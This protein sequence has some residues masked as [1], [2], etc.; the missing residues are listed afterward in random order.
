MY[1]VWHICREIGDA[2]KLDLDRRHKLET[3]ALHHDIAEVKMGDIPTPTKHF[4]EKAA[5]VARGAV[6]LCE[7]E[8]YPEYVVFKTTIENSD[9]LLVLL[10]K[11]ADLI[12]AVHFLEEE[13]IGN[14]ALDVK[15]LLANQLAELHTKT[16]QD[17][18]F[19][20]ENIKAVWDVFNSICPGWITH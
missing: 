2:M 14:H 18:R 19:K 6:D 10:M 8:A 9:P 17:E 7:L 13:A 4:I 16:E 11:M 1:R 20:H 15:R 5:D 12:E 3:L